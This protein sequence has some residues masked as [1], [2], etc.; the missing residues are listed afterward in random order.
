MTKSVLGLT[1]LS[2]RIRVSAIWKVF[3]YQQ[4]THLLTCIYQIS[5]V[6]LCL[7]MS[8]LRTYCKC[9]KDWLL[10]WHQCGR[11]W[12]RCIQRMS[13]CAALWKNCGRRAVPCANNWRNTRKQR[14]TQTTVVHRFLK[15]P[16]KTRYFKG[17]G[18]SSWCDRGMRNR[19]LSQVRTWPVRCWKGTRLCQPSCWFADN[20]SHSDRIPPLQEG[21]HLQMLQQSLYAA[22][23]WKSDC[24]R[25]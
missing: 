13:T 2:T 12:M 23:T 18:R 4:N 3:D 14:R 15:N 19:F 9:L 25:P 22:Q 5:F 10:R 24:V 6:P 21:L 7:W 20:D 17:I 1:W 8:K 16:W 11:A